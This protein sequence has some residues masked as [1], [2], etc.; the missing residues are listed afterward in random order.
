MSAP[1]RPCVYDQPDTLAQ[2]TQH[3]PSTDNPVSG[4]VGRWYA[5]CN[6]GQIVADNTDYDTAST[7]LDTHRAAYVAQTA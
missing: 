7:A 3:D 6:C 1:V 2:L 5:R 4:S